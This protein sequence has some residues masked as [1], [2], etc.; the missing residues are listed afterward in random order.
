M[1]ATLEASVAHMKAQGI[2][3]MG[4]MGFCWGGWV[5][6]YACSTSSSVKGDFQANLI[7]HPSCHLENYFGGSAQALFDSIEVPTLLLPANG[8]PAE[9]WEEG[10]W[11]QSVKARHPSSKTITFG[12]VEH[13]FIPRGDISIPEKREAVDQAMLEFSTFL[14]EHL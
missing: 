12:H 9:Y 8:D 1:A 3:K 2:E 6:S 4:I 10:A 13:G 5:S 7:G 14:K 11:F